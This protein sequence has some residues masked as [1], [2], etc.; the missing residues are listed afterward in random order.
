MLVARNH[1]ALER[2]EREINASGGASCHVD[3]DVG[4]EADVRRIVDSAVERFGGF[5]TWINNAGV[6]V[7][8]RLEEVANDDHRRLF[9]T[10]FWG[11]VYGSTVAVAHLKH[12]GG[13]LI[14]VGSVA[15]DL[16]LPVQG[17]YSASKHAVKGFTDALRM[18]LEEE[19]APV[20]VTL[21][22]PTSINTPFPQHAK[23]YTDKEPK[24]PPP[25]YAPEEVARAILHA[26]AHPRRDIYVG[27]SAKLMST[28]RS[29][30]PRAA[31]LVGERVLLDQEFRA[32]AP[33]NPEG[34]LYQAGD[35]GNVHGDH[36]GSVRKTSLYTR[37]SLN[38]L[39]TGSLLAAAGVVAAAIFG[40]DRAKR[41]S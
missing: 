32:E 31:D 2:L 12:R 29:H 40:S 20:S 39:V 33:R 28:L 8:G 26:A 3:A 24:L 4:S 37:A 15:S 17:M 35:D 36:P 10:N 38:P 1:E 9:E 18:E 19:G 5:D 25:V 14:N 7:Y 13:A 27:G 16:A 41:R 6:T 34:A 30:A 21:V 22:K 11:V 23:N